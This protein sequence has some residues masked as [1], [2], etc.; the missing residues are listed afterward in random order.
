MRCLWHVV[1]LS[2]RS[3][4]GPQILRLEFDRFAVASRD[5]HVA[6]T[7]A[8]LMMLIPGSQKTV[9]GDS[10]W[11]AIPFAGKATVSDRVFVLY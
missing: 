2:L 5:F 7:D 6:G 4:R 1:G 9:V 3:F 8:M 11:L 10:C